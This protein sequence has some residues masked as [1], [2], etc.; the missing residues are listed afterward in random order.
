MTLNGKTALVTGG[1]RGIGRAIVRRL[2]RDGA[3]VVFSFRA[4][5]AA[6]D[7]LVRD[8]P[9]TIAVQADQEDIGSIEALFEPVQDGLDILVNNAAINPPTP[10]SA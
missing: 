4:D 1:S 6:A 8:V 5:K 9:D 10:I 2:A 3:R 7:R